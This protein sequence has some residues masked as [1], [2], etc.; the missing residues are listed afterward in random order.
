MLPLNERHLKKYCIREI[1][2]KVGILNFGGQYNHL[3]L[4]RI[5]E[6]GFQGVLI[7]PHEDI[8][9]VEKSFDC[10]IIS[11]GPWN[12]PQDIPRTGNAI[13]YI[14][15]F[16]G[17]ILGICLGHQLM[18]YAY[19]GELGENSPEFGGV[20]VY[21][22]DE[23]TIL[24]GLPKEFTA[25]ESH[26]ISVLKAPREFRVIAHSSRVPVEAMVWE[27]GLRFGVQFHPEVG[28][29]EFGSL[30]MRNFLSLCGE[31]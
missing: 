25:W 13:N 14:L 27:G 21:V 18:A 8:N 31:E 3:I 16:T 29:T 22:D 6:L 26:N 17:P 20:K 28:H 23:D 19:G 10:L 5:T 4:R 7:D 24:K 9:H 15:E 30:I 12:I 11:G 1:M 2:T